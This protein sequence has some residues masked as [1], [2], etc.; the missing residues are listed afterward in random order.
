MNKL[1]NVKTYDDLDVALGAQVPFTKSLASDAL[2][3]IGEFVNLIDPRAAEALHNKAA[4]I[5]EPYNEKARAAYLRLRD[6]NLNSAL[7]SQFN[8]PQNAQE[9]TSTAVNN[10]VASPLSKPTNVNKFD[11]M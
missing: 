2:H 7:T 8:E 5:M 10:S 6:T 9:A 1:E 11:Q 3:L 4:E